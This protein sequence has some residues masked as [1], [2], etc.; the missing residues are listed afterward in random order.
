MLMREVRSCGPNSG[1]GVLD[2]GGEME[3]WE[4]DSETELES[5]GA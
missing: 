1:T 3:A 5:D 4:L 2:E